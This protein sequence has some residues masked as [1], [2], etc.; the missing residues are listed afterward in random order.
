MFINLSHLVRHD[1]IIII[2]N[3]YENIEKINNCVPT[4]FFDWNIYSEHFFI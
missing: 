3:N 1:I 2:K 4:S